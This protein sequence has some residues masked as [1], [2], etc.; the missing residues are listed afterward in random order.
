MRSSLRAASRY[1]KLIAVS[2]F[3]LSIALALGILAL[4]VSN[5]VLLLPPSAPDAGRLVTIYERTPDEDVS[6]IS[7]PDY[8]YLRQH[9][10]V[11]T[12]IAGAPGS[13][14]LSED[15]DDSGRHVKAMSRPVSENYFAVLGL[16][17]FLGSFF[18]PGADRRN[19]TIITWQCWKRLGSDLHIV[20]KTLFGHRVVGVAPPE[21]T[22]G[23]YGV[24]GDLFKTLNG[25]NES[26]LADREAH[27]LL[28][29]ARLKPGVTLEQAQAEMTALSA[30]LAVAF[31]KEN[32]GRTGVVT[33]ATLLPPDALADMTWAAGALNALVLMVLLIACANVANLL[34][35]AAVG[36]RQEAAIK[37][38]IGAP[39]RRL[40]AGFLA[41]S[42]AL[43]LVSA[44]LG[45]AIAYAVATRFSDFTYSF[46]M[47]GAFSFSINLRLDGA[48]LG[49]TL[50]L[51]AVAT[52]ATGLAP[53][54]YAS[55]PNL[56]QMIGGEIVIG[57]TGRHARR[58]AL[59]IVQVAVC[60]LLLIGMGLCERNLYNL[61][62]ADLGFQA[63]NLVA[64]SVFPRAEGYDTETKGRQFYERVRQAAA[65][66]PGIASVSLASD[67]PLLGGG[68]VQV[69][70]PGAS[71]PRS[72]AQVTVDRD[73]FTTLGLPILAGRAFDA[74]DR[75]GGIPA[76]IVNRKMAD[77]YWPGQDHLGKTITV[78][79]PT[80][81]FTVVGVAANSKYENIDEPPTPFFYW[82]LSQNY[83]P[84]IE[85]VARTKGDPQATMGTLRGT[86][87]GLGMRVMADPFTFDSWM[88]FDLFGERLAATG[89]GILSGL[90]LLLAGIGLL[91]AISYSVSE[92]KRELGIRVALG[93]RPAQLLA[94]VLRQTALVTGSGVFIGSALG[95]AASAALRS[96]FYRIGALEWT[97]LAPVAAGMMVVS[98]AIA[99]ISARPWL[100]VDPMEAVRHM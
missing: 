24:N 81:K 39:R 20:G 2:C 6:H 3:S 51:I 10:H 9:N 15:I 63:R 78:L 45:Y 47:W 26:W 90:A 23:F 40:I 74:S 53:A 58:N 31:P 54:L 70:T 46:P 16:R 57:G 1:W 42:L 52:L 68:T 49:L 34:L 17:P 93:A 73:Y 95:V 91:G 87:R 72:I 80:R 13:I 61:R 30:Q 92:R 4:S 77:M 18:T 48:V 27:S 79:K 36:R 7:Y 5:T 75:E 33:R 55:S 56:S 19:E 98:L 25:D 11:F 50:A 76:A 99:Y 29:T 85:L 38:A 14:E 22:G 100:R 41:E 59:V 89:A 44:A 62:H 86:M 96:E 43:C 84:Q 28:L 67:L 21:F 8:Q 37:L 82:A 35:A 69:D 97:V 83:V 64:A 88:D 66:V 65:A 71:K 32:K 12:D 60:T 94:M